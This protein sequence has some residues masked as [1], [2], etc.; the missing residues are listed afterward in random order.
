MRGG[1]RVRGGVGGRSSK[2]GLLGC[3]KKGAR[4]KKTST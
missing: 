3:I 4:V 2:T 1:E